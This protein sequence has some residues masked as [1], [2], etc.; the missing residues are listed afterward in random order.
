MFNKALLALDELERWKERQR[1]IE[2]E[3]EDGQKGKIVNEQVVYYTNLLRDMKQ[4]IC[5]PDLLTL[6][7]SMSR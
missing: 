3:T 5:R 6:L 4:E 1:R 2:D 7:R